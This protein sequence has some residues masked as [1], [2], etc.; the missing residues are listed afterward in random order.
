MAINIVGSGLAIIHIKPLRVN[1][2]QLTH[3]KAK[4]RPRRFNHQVI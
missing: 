3:T 2:I 4:V 1:A